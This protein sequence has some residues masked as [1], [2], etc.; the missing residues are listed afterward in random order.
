MRRIPMSNNFWLGSNELVIVDRGYP[1]RIVE[2]YEDYDVVFIGTYQQC[3]E[4]CMKR[5]LDYAESC[6]G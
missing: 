6:I 3:Y 4:Y 2:R 1:C 5:E